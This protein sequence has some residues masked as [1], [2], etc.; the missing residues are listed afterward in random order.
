MTLRQSSQANSSLTDHLLSPSNTHNNHANNNHN[1]NT[2]QPSFR[3]E[4]Y[5][6]KINELSNMVKALRDR[7]TVL[8]GEKEGY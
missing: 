1:H 2:S 4:E 5:E 3:S 7:L 8:D 6:S